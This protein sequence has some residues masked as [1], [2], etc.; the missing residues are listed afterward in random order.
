MKNQINIFKNTLKAVLC[1]AVLFS[2]VSC[3]DSFKF[4]LPDTG[5]VVDTSLPIAG[6]SSLPDA[7]NYRVL[8]F[9]NTSF[10]SNKYAWDFGANGVVCD[11]VTIDNTIVDGSTEIQLIDNLPAID[12][13]TPI[14]T[15][16]FSKDSL[17]IH[18]VLKLGTSSTTTSKDPSFVLFAA[19]EGQYPVSLTSSDSNDASNN[20]TVDVDVV[21]KFVP[22]PVKI[23]N[24]DFND[25]TDGWK[26]ASFTGGNT[27]PFNSSSDG[28]PLNY[29]GSDSGGTKTAGAKWAA[30]T[31]LTP[32]TAAS[33]YAYQAIKVSP[34]TADRGKVKYILEFE[35]SIKDDIA[36][37][38]AGGRRIVAE[39][40]ED[41][42]T[43]GADARNSSPVAIH[44]GTTVLGKGTFTKVELEFTANSSG[45]MAIWIYGFTPVDAYVDNVKVYAVP[46]QF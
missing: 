32:Y 28:S 5:G 16:E 31:S 10:E 3:E 42:Y 23:V 18:G 20:V 35:Y 19:G 24:G 9:T 14:S 45:N 46:G 33:R 40:L 38:P 17:K 25:G 43:D 8:S 15:T 26:I 29:D 44:T 41:H 7:V 34:S 21:D 13:Y 30:S 6:F 39:I 1:T 36:T 11:T 2:A 12:G 27:N 4:D 22:I 37:D